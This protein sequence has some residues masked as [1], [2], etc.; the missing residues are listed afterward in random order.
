MKTLS[1]YLLSAAATGF[2]CAG[3]TKLAFFLFGICFL[4]ST[5][6]AKGNKQ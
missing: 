2:G 5:T 4:I 6:E 3:G 1:I